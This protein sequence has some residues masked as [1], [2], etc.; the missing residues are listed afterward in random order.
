MKRAMFV[1]VGGFLTLVL[2]SPGEAQIPAR[3]L[4]ALI[5][6]AGVDGNDTYQVGP[7][8]QLVVVVSGDNGSSAKVEIT[9]GGDGS[10]HLL[11]YS[12][13]D[14]SNTLTCGDAIQSVS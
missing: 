9:H 3:G 12:D 7:S 5:C 10:A 14:H 8:G 1:A 6:L 4:S 11:T 13:E 2:A